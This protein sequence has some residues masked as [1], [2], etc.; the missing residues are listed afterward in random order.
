MSAISYGIPYNLN[1]PGDLS[2]AGN[3]YVNNL[4]SGTSAG[5]ILFPTLST[6][7]TGNGTSTVNWNVL[8]QPVASLTLSGNSTMAPTGMVP[9]CSAMLFVTQGSTGKLSLA[10][11]TGSV[12]WSY[13]T[14][15]IYA[16]GV[17]KTDILQFVSD[18]TWLYGY[19]SSEY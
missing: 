16:T 12:K 19:Y 2:V 8:T 18:G 11:P 6:L 7:T 9:G 15:P 14:S 10:W 3:T 5:L 13:G 17:G 4:V 1:L